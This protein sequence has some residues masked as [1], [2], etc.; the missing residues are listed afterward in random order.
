MEICLKNEKVKKKKQI[1]QENQ[2]Y[3]YKDVFHLNKFSTWDQKRVKKMKKLFKYSMERSLNVFFKNLIFTINAKI[4]KGIF[5][6]F[7]DIFFKAFVDIFCKF[8]SF[9]VYHILLKFLIIGIQ[10]KALLP[11]RELIIE[12]LIKAMIEISL[13]KIVKPIGVYIAKHII[14]IKQTCLK[15]KK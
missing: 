10:K 1:K 3:T 11:L 2:P 13:L 7:I 4:F 15:K 8:L 14:K 6:Y 5:K 9:T 12:N